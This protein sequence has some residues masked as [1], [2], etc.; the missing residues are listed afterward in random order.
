MQAYGHIPLSFEANQG[1]TSA[2]VGF[3]ARGNRVTAASRNL[4]SYALTATLNH[5][6]YQ[7]ALNAGTRTS[8]KAQSYF[9][10]LADQTITYGAG[11]TTVSGKITSSP[12][13]PTGSVIV[14]LKGV[15]HAARITSVGNFTATFNTAR[16]PAG[17]YTITYK[18]SGSANFQAARATT[19]L[20]VR[21][22]LTAQ[23][24]QGNGNSVIVLRSPIPAART[25]GRQRIPIVALNL[26]GQSGNQLKLTI[27]GNNRKSVFNSRTGTYTTTL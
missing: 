23:V 1:Q 16:L 18:Y 20:T 21:Y 5:S 9:S 7:A 22:G 17:S 10:S 19:R 3:L 8:A 4:G 24:N 12:L 13:I 2:Q 14:T 25:S 11:R 27:P 15:K 6:N 26:V